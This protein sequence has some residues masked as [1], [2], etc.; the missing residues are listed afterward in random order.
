MPGDV[1]ISHIFSNI[2]DFE[3]VFR[4]PGFNISYVTPAFNLKILLKNCSVFESYELLLLEGVC[5]LVCIYYLILLL[6]GNI[7]IGLVLD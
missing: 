2:N 4:H 6:A 1:L 3:A 5:I 7:D